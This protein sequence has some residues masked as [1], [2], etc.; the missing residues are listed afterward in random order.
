MLFTYSIVCQA[1]RRKYLQDIST[2]EKLRAS[3]DKLIFILV[4]KL[5]VKYGQ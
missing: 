3:R 2:R 4:E 5:S 1:L